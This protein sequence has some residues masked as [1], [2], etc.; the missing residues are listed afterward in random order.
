MRSNGLTAATYTP[1]ADLDPR[2]A[3]ALLDE[4]KAQGVAAYT[5][6]VESATTAGFDRPEFRVDV[7]DRLYVDARASA[8]VLDQISNEHP[9]LIDDNDDLAWARLVAGFDAPLESAVAP[10]PVAEDLGVDEAPRD[11]RDERKDAADAPTSAPG[12][13][14]PR[15]RWGSRPGEGG[16]DDEDFLLSTS[17]A[18]PPDE[19]DRFVPDPPPPLPKLAPYKQVA[20]LGLIGGPLLLVIVVLSNLALPTWASVLAVVGFVGGFVTLVVTMDDNA[21]DGSGPDDGAVV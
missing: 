17:R 21:H 9:E 1:V 3:N 7:R 11:E 10:W 20:W 14:R 5:K 19:E 6:P 13:S 15:A 16:S 18:R 8:Q 4:L 2:I 12:D